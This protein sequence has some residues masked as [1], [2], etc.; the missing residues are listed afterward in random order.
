MFFIP[1]IEIKTTDQ[2]LRAE[3]NRSPI[4]RTK[5]NRSLYFLNLGLVF[6]FVFLGGFLFLGKTMHWM[7]LLFLRRIAVEFLGILTK[8][9]LM[10]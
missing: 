9:L 2:I 4:I 1:N 3:R 8:S 6:M 7:F 5:F 10:L